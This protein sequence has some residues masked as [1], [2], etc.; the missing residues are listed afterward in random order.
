MAQKVLVQ[1]PC[2]RRNS[3]TAGATTMA[4]EEKILKCS[5][6]CIIKLKEVR[7]KKRWQTVL[8]ITSF[9]STSLCAFPFHFLAVSQ[10]P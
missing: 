8:I 3:E 5:E 2:K 9:M 6:K 10:E 4:A 7:Q 1:E